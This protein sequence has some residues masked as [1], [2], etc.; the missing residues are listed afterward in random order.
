M[1]GIQQRRS[2]LRVTMQVRSYYQLDYIYGGAGGRRIYNRHHKDDE[3]E[4]DWLYT[5]LAALNVLLIPMQCV[6]RL[7]IQ[8]PY[9]PVSPS[10][11]ETNQRSV[12]ASISP[13]EPMVVSS[14]DQS[15][16]SDSTEDWD[17]TEARALPGPAASY[18]HN[19]GGRSLWE[20][21][22]QEAGTP[23][24]RQGPAD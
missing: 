17:I 4:L 1:T 14:R 8:A 19:Q 7:T 6:S 11:M 23:C 20:R 21:H 16:H 13:I 9:S 18:R 22:R 12:P 2:H 24:A 15:M 3:K 10:S 5:R